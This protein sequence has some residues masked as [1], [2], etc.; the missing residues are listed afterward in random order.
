MDGLQKLDL[1]IKVFGMGEIKSQPVVPTFKIQNP[2]LFKMKVVP[3][4]KFCRLSTAY[5]IYM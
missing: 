3:G 5:E 1:P 4:I 2:L